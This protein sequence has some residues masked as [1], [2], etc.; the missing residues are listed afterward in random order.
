MFYHSE[1]LSV[2]ALEGRL[3]LENT[4]VVCT[5]YSSAGTDMVLDSRFV[6]LLILSSY[7]CPLPFIPTLCASPLT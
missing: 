3:H 2:S 7:P 6:K 1:L 5:G 4:F